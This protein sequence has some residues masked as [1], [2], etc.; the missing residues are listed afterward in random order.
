VRAD[1]SNLEYLLLIADAL[2]PLREEIVF[3]G[4][5]VAGLLITDPLAEGIRATKDVDAVVE[6]ATLVQY[7]Q[8]GKCLPALGFTRDPS[9][10]VICRWKH[11]ASGVLFDLMPTH[12]QVLGFSNAWYPEAVK[13]SVR[14]QLNDDIDIRLI[15]AVCFV[16]TK[17]EA[18][19]SRGSG[20]IASSHDLEDILTIVDGRPSLG[21]ELARGAESLNSYVK[22]QLRALLSRPS[23][24]NYLPGLLTDETR[25]P[26]VISRLRKMTN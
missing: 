22:Q 7:Y 18:F 9:S 11:V 4:G 20:D 17:L 14:M 5:S 19:N 3:V 1:D 15:S 26:L 23:F 24:E 2:G 25:V 12:P 21:E 6:A 13:T 8:V 10:E 16:A